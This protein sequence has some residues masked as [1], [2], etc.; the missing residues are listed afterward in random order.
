M[1]SSLYI[2][3]AF[4]QQFQELQRHKQEEKTKRTKIRK[5]LAKIRKRQTNIGQNWLKITKSSLTETLHNKNQFS[6]KGKQ[7]EKQQNLMNFL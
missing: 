5:K 2:F 3:D 7:E 1:K 4:Q 6:Q